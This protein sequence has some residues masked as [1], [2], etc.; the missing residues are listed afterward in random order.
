LD[1]SAETRLR[2]YPRTSGDFAVACSTLFSFDFARFAAIE[3][4][5]DYPAQ[6]SQSRFRKVFN[7]ITLSC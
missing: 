4:Q 2:L 5:S 7:A 3:L 6:F 1:V